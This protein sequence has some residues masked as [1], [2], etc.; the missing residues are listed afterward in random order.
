M[1]ALATAIQAQTVRQTAICCS[2]VMMS[3]CSSNDAAECFTQRLIHLTQ[4]ASLS[5]YIEARGSSSAAAHG[6]MPVCECDATMYS[7]DKCILLYIFQPTW[8]ILTTVSWRQSSHATLAMG[9]C[10]CKRQH[11]CKCVHWVCLLHSSST[12]PSTTTHE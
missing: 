4:V 5:A 6:T 11:V 7:P 8:Q 10:I 3:A 12:C 2:A 1:A 9:T